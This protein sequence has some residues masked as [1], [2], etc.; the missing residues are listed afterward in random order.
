[1]RAAAAD[2]LDARRSQ[3]LAGTVHGRVERFLRDELRRPRRGCPNVR[4]HLRTFGRGLRRHVQ[5]GSELHVR[6]RRVLLR[7]HGHLLA[8]ERLRP[9]DGAGQFRHVRFGAVL[10][11][12]REPELHTTADYHR[13][14]KL[15][16]AHRHVV[17]PDATDWARHL[18]HR[19]R[20]RAGRS[21]GLRCLRRAGWRSDVSLRDETVGVQRRRRH[22]RLL[23]LHVQWPDRL[24]VRREPRR[25]HVERLLRSL[26][27]VAM[28]TRGRLGPV[29]GVAFGNVRGVQC[30]RDGKRDAERAGHVLLPLT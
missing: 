3:H 7:E 22:A 16:D 26:D 12:W 10:R 21:S 8:G 6:L 24:R 4:L 14:A 28:R 17:Q 11:R 30:R 25:L 19:E 18:R 13:P 9:G 5:L 1:M 27:A 15:V 29:P 23:V 20:M 2:R